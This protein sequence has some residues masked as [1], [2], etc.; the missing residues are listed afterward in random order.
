MTMVMMI[1]HAYR[2][3]I[4]LYSAQLLQLRS[5]YSR[6]RGRRWL[7]SMVVVI[8]TRIRPRS[9]CRGLSLCV[10][11]C[12][13]WGRALRGEGDRDNHVILLIAHVSLADESLLWGGHDDLTLA[14][15][16]LPRAKP[17]GIIVSLD[18][19]M[20]VWVRAYT[21]E[22]VL[23]YV[24]MPACVSVLIVVWHLSPPT[25]ADAYTHERAHALGS[26]GIMY[27]PPPPKQPWT[28]ISAH[29]AT[30]T[31]ETYKSCVMHRKPCFTE[32][33]VLEI[34]L[35]LPSHPVF[36]ARHRIQVSSVHT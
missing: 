35:L 31:L 36:G 14:I 9:C 33:I 24:C 25:H 34:S 2:V 26:N 11:A 10:C 20:H 22:C 1:K 17:N 32:E 23:M 13:C 29:M 5:Q 30:H 18:L 8:R 21:W 3:L 4:C 15:E 12:R 6:W 28:I 19:C 7:Q 27:A 16:E